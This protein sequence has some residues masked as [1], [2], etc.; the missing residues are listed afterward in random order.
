MGNCRSK[1]ND[2]TWKEDDEPHSQR[3]KDILSH[4][5]DIKTLF[6]PDLRLFPI[7]LSLVASQLTLSYYAKDFSWPLYVTVAWVVGGTISHSLSLASH[8]LSHGLCFEST[9]ANDVLGMI[10]NCG[11]GIPSHATFKK[12]HIDHH[13]KQGHDNYDAD[14]PTRLEAQLF[15]SMLGKLIFVAFQPFFYAL[16]PVLAYPKQMNMMEAINWVVVM[17]SNGVV[18]MNLGAGSL[19]YLWLSDLLGLGLHPIAGHFI[20]EHYEFEENQETYSYYGPLNYLT[21][22]V[23]YHNE[24][25][26]FPRISGFNLP[27]V[28]EIAPEYYE[29]PQ[30]ESW[31]MVLWNFCMDESKSPFSRVKRKRN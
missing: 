20:A 1:R 6:G 19:V 2:F 25:H 9:M 12:Y 10:A 27:K 23:G 16:R 31:P 11:Q 18:Y 15:Q 26:D 14:L 21:F 8:E 22:N 24:H 28:K 30:H 5:P 29:L 7:V 17:T 13:Q 4:H 3:R